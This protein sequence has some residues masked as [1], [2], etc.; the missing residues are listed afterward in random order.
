MAHAVGTLA[1]PPSPGDRRRRLGRARAGRVG[2]RVAVALA[3]RPDV[4]PADQTRPGTVVLVPG[5]GGSQAALDHLAGR[6][7][8]A[9][10]AAVVLTLPGSGDG[11]LSV[12]ADALD[13]LVGQTLRHSPS[14]DVIGYSAG[15]VVVRLW[16]DRYPAAR[17]ARRVVTLGAPLHGAGIAAVGSAVVRAPVRPPVSSCSPARHCCASSTPPRY[18]PGCPGCRS[19]PHRPDGHPAVIVAVG[20]CGQRRGPGRLRRQYPP[21]WTVAD[22]SPGGGPDPAPTGSESAAHA[23]LGGRLPV[24][25]SGRWIL[26]VPL[27]TVVRPCRAGRRS[28]RRSRAVPAPAASRA[29]T[30]MAARPSGSAARRTTSQDNGRGGRRASVA[31]CRCPSRCW[32]PRPGGGPPPRRRR[33]PGTAGTRR[34]RASHRRRP[35]SCPR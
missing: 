25:S 8:A 16:V 9:G 18:R 14:V 11:D 31:G 34:R 32:S 30:V 13:T 3:T 21:T 5:Y 22:R 33:R 7:R 12:Q 1:A 19:G 10:R 27:W 2:V 15:G 35:P 4:A 6:L 26:N 23:S 17:A 24:P 29:S 20:R 28:S